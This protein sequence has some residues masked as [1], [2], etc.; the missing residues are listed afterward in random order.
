M[1]RFDCRYAM[2]L[3]HRGVSSV[4]CGEDIIDAI[5]KSNINAIL[6]WIADEDGNEYV[7]KEH[8]EPRGP[9][10][11][12]DYYWVND[13]TGEVLYDEWENTDKPLLINPIDITKTTTNSG[14]L[15]PDG[16]FYECGFEEHCR[17]ADTLHDVGIVPD[18]TDREMGKEI[19][20]RNNYEYVLELRKW[21]K[22]SSGRIIFKT[23]FNG[24]SLNNIQKKEMIKYFKNKGSDT[25][26]LFDKNVSFETFLNT[27][28]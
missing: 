5:K 3:H 17:F 22:L 8:D 1:K 23:D 16:L 7:I 25:V 6:V 21:I 4:V 24:T 26:R 18:N 20:L 19:W 14:W 15:S 27:D 9:K 11:T 2:Y 28:Y 13:E 10:Q 12:F